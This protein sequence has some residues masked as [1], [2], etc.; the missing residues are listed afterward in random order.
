MRLIIEANNYIEGRPLKS[1]VDVAS[2]KAKQL[3]TS[4]IWATSKLY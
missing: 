1:H 2:K 3:N 4:V